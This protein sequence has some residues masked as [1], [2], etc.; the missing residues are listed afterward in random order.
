[1]D[2]HKDWSVVVC[3]VGGGQ[4]IN[5]GEAG[6]SEWLESINRSFKHWDVYISS[7]LQ[8]SEYNSAEIIKGLDPIVNIIQEDSLHLATSMRSFRSENVS[9]LVKDLLDVN[10]ESAIQIINEIHDDYPIVITRDLQKAKIGL[11]LKPGDR[12]DMGLLHPLRLLD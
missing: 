5:I 3:L 7:K 6:I 1:M 9:K 12:K 10:K 4:E 2:R 8:D 11:S